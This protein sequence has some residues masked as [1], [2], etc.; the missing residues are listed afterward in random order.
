MISSVAVWMYAIAGLIAPQAMIWLLR[1][2]RKRS[3]TPSRAWSIAIWGIAAG[4]FLGAAP[5]MPPVPES[6]SMPPSA[7]QASA[8]AL[9]ESDDATVEDAAWAAESARRLALADAAAEEALS[10]VHPEGCTLTGD[11]P[12]N[13]LR[14]TLCQFGIAANGDGYPVTILR[15]QIDDDMLLAFDHRDELRELDR[16]MLNMFNMWLQAQ[17]AQV[18]QMY[19][20]H[21]TRKLATVRNRPYNRSPQVEHHE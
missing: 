6:E 16:A 7:S 13:A 14:E 17:N 19:V 1:P 4:M 8:E 9:A 10:L 5:H 18:G 21:G 12:N 2:I 20:L 15:V 3:T 11:I